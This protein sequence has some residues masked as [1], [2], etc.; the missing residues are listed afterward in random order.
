MLKTCVTTLMCAL[1]VS[2]GKSNSP[3]QSKLPDQDPKWVQS[4]ALN[5]DSAVKHIGK[6][7]ELVATQSTAVTEINGV[8]AIG[9]G[10]TVDGVVIG[11]IKCTFF[12]QDAY[13]GKEQYMWRG[14]WGCQAG[15]SEAEV[16]GAIKEDGTKAFDYIYMSPVTLQ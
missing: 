2:C 12:Q 16:N 15:R 7:Q 11:A 8:R 9:V 4:V 10:Q 14:R 3:K 6:T 5:D 13:A 1:L